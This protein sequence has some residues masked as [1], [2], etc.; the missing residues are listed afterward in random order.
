[1]SRY[2][3]T[4]INNLT[5]EMVKAPIECDAFT[6]IGFRGPMRATGVHDKMKM[7]CKGITEHELACAIYSDEHLRKAARTGFWQGLKLD[8]AEWLMR[9]KKK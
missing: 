8:L 2:Q 3:I 5:G 9:R 1:M 4:V 6:V 7:W